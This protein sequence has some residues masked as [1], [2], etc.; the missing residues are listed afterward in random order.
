MK[1]TSVGAP[2]GADSR[3]QFFKDDNGQMWKATAERKVA[4]L[5]LVD[6]VDA[7]PAELAITVTVSP[8][9]ADGKALRDGDKPIIIDSHTH[10][11]NDTELTQ[12]G[13]DPVARVTAIV[14]QRIE[15]GQARLGGHKA[16]DDFVA[17]WNK[18]AKIGGVVDTAKLAKP[19]PDPPPVPPAQA[20][21]GQSQ[22]P[23]P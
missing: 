14:A 17:T 10:T 7:A 16:V 6:G 5:A 15:L 19:L 8:V 11:F 20:A 22:T 12:P 21:P 9:D 1:I 13:F 23:K 2:T 4:R 3:Y 18:P